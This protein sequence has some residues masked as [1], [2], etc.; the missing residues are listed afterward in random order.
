[1]VTE[2]RPFQSTRAAAFSLRFLFADM[3][4][5]RRDH[6]AAERARHFERREQLASLVTD[7]NNWLLLAHLRHLQFLL[8]LCANCHDS[9][10]VCEL[11][12][13]QPAPHGDCDAAQMPCPHCQPGDARPQLPAGWQSKASTSTARDFS[14]MPVLCLPSEKVSLQRAVRTR[15]STRVGDYVEVEFGATWATRR[16]ETYKVPGQW[17]QCRIVALKH[18]ELHVVLDPSPAKAPAEFG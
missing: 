13:N 9:R 14:V 7:R 1:M 16:G 15:G 8:M 18:S 3:R 10:W 12:P 11:H 6:R 4:R 5:A 2:E 17:R